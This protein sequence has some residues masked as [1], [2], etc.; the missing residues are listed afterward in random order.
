MGGSVATRI[1][2]REECVEG[3]RVN[4]YNSSD[5]KVDEVRTDAFGDFKFD[6][7]LPRSGVYTLRISHEGRET[8]IPAVELEESSLYLGVIYIEP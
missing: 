4:L 3:A 2:G 5:E 7:I 1:D 8:S 6:G